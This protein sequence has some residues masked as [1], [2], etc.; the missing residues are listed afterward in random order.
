MRRY[1]QG[2]LDFTC[3]VYAVIN[4]LSVIHN[5]DLAT[6]RMILAE[7]LQALSA[8]PELW[9]AFLYNETDHYWLVDYCLARW[10]RQGRLALRVARPFALGASPNLSPDDFLD[11]APLFRLDGPG[12]NLHDPRVSSGSGPASIRAGA[13]LE[14]E[15]VFQTLAGY[16]Q[17]GGKRKAVIF[18]FLRFLPGSFTPIILHW[19]TA[20]RAIGDTV[21][22]H[23]ASSEPGAVHAVERASLMP[24]DAP[25]PFYIEPASVVLLEALS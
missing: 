13:G 6:G 10:C 9:R 14:A 8:R 21:F 3:A 22:L 18:R 11:G 25:A 7:T 20:F 1:M 23:D 2:T 15:R 12:D 16:L 19:T 24:G 5:L 4:S 17:P